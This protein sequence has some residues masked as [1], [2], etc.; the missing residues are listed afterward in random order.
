[1]QEILTFQVGDFS[2]LFLQHMKNLQV[3]NKRYRMTK[4]ANVQKHFSV[5]N[6][7]LEFS[8]KSRRFEVKDFYY[9]L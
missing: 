1:M 6:Y 3:R 4:K 9:T 5:H 7:I 8:W 2:T